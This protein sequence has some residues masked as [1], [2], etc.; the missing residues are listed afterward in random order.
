MAVLCYL[1]KLKGG[2]GLTSDAHFLHDQ[3]VPYLILY[4]QTKFQ[5]RTFF[6]SQDIKKMCY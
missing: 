5:S 1:T 6:S 2:L 4:Q 3:N